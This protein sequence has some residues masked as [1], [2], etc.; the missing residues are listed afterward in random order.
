MTP[1]PFP[2]PVPRPGT[3]AKIKDDTHGLL[4]RQTGPCFGEDG[5]IGPPAP[6]LPTPEQVFK[7]HAPRIYR[8]A[9]RMMGSEADAEDVTSEVLLQVVRKLHTFRGE[10]SLATWLHRV[11]ANAA[12]ALRRQRACQKERPLAGAAEQ[13]L[14][15]GPR[16]G[17]P[18]PPSSPDQKAEGREL[19]RL[20]EEAVADLPPCYREVFV[21]SDV[22]GLPNAEIGRRLGLS[23][24]AVKSR[25]HRAR[26]MMR[27]SLA[28]HFEEPAT[29][30]SRRPPAGR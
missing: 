15:D 4:P 10:S 3:G 19:G 9:L 23:L 21:L 29:T 2:L 11:T 28:R 20:I 24:P 22:D 17:R 1:R 30:G 5:P 13:A 7:E 14:A 27:H 18:V 16:A 12:L 26:L 6:L 8:L 25:L